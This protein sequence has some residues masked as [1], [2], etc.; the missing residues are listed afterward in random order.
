MLSFLP[1]WIQKNIEKFAHTV[2]SFYLNNKISNIILMIISLRDVSPKFY[3]QCHFLF[4]ITRTHNS[5]AP[6]S[7]A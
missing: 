3:T 7:R 1:V 2:F 5:F 4:G 6:F